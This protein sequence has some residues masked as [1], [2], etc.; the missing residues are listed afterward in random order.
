MRGLDIPHVD[1]VDQP[2]HPE[3]HSKDYITAWAARRVPAAGKAS[4]S[5]YRFLK[6]MALTND[7]Q[8]ILEE[9]D[10]DQS[11]STSEESHNS[12]VKPQMNHLKRFQAF[13][14]DAKYI[15]PKKIRKQVIPVMNVKFM[16]ALII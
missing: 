5:S 11:N 16:Y 2:G 3:M 7:P 15:R 14:R 8:R 12:Q 1:V 9:S 10:E 6:K 4:P 13:A